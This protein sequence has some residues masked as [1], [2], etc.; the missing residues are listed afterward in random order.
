MGASSSLA[1]RGTVNLTSLCNGGRLA[2][3]AARVQ[4]LDEKATHVF[5]RCRVGRA[6][7]EA[8]EG[9]DVAD[10][11]VAGLLAEFAH[12][13]VFEHAAAKVTDGL[14]AHRGLLS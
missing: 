3:P 10:M 8:G 11:V 9:P 14:L 13:H 6:A 2:I 5:C 1:R 7:E 12:R 4:Q